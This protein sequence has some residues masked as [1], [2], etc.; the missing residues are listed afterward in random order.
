MLLSTIGSESAFSCSSGV[1][2]ASSSMR[3]S[4]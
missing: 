2:Q 1:I 4:T 3:S